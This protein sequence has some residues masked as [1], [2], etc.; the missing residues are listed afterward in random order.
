MLKMLFYIIVIGSFHISHLVSCMYILYSPLP[1]F[2]QAT[3]FPNPNYERM[4]TTAINCET[5]NVDYF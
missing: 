5:F 4:G 3:Y 2:Y 1:F